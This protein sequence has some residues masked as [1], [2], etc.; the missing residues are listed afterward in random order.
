M[1]RVWLTRGQRWT[2]ACSLMLRISFLTLPSDL[3]YS[4]FVGISSTV[5]MSSA[6]WMNYYYYNNRFMTLCPGLPRWVGTRRTNHS[7]FY[8]SRH[9]GVAVA[10]V[11]PYESYLHFAP[12]DNH[13]S[14]SSVWMKPAIDWYRVIL[15]TFA[16]I[17][18]CILLHMGNRHAVWRP[19]AKWW[20]RKP[21]MIT[22]TT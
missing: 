7:G 16:Y 3:S 10:S 6:V 8:W 13:A 12:E 1:K 17:W 14:T 5:H 20:L 2:R 4:N 9:D 21:R 15:P 11:E 18:M 19:N 22:Q